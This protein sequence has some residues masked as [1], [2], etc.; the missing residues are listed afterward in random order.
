LPCFCCNLNSLEL[1]IFTC[2]AF[3]PGHRHTSWRV[4]TSF[5]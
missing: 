3:W 1:M 4:K 5:C 2:R